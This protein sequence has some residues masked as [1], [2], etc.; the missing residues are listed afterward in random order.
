M[1]AISVNQITTYQVK[2]WASTILLTLRIEHRIFLPAIS[3]QAQVCRAHFEAIFY[4]WR[5]CMNL[6]FSYMVSQLPWT[7]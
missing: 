3:L 5:A 2:F 4:M 6:F 1:H 7:K